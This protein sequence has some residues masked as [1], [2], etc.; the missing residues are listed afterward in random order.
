MS[1][2][3][4]SAVQ[5]IYHHGYQTTTKQTLWLLISLSNRLKTNPHT[6]PNTPM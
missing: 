4:Q 6:D 5:V 3:L 1:S 2:S